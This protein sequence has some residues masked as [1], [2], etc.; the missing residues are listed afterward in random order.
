MSTLFVLPLVISLLLPGCNSSTTLPRGGAACKTD[1]HC[2]LAGVCTAGRC[3]CDP[4]WTD[5]NC[6]ALDLLPLATN[7]LAS[8]G[9]YG[10]HPN[11]SSWG[12]LAVPIKN[13]SSPTGT[14]YHLFVAEMA[15]GCGLAHWG[16]NSRVAHAVA[17]TPQGPFRRAGTAVG[18]FS[19]NPHIVHN[20][21]GL[22][23]ERFVLFHIN[24]GSRILIPDCASKTPNATRPD[25]NTAGA[26]NIRTAPTP[27]GPWRG[28]LSGACNNPA[29][30]RHQNGTWFQLCRDGGGGEQYN[31]TLVRS[32]N[33]F[34]G[35]WAPVAHVGGPVWPSDSPGR[36]N[37][38]DVSEAYRSFSNHPP[39]T[40]PFLWRTNAHQTSLTAVINSL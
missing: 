1:E 3:V 13:A 15:N 9:A 6:S 21:S 2:Q 16:S 8:G 25:G 29:P 26:G 12:G 30:Y 18:V 22:D 14:F 11:V 33:G 24:H 4:G 5:A 40:P 10:Y 27:H 38:E 28:G 17:E 34:K 32:A 19:H 7:D 23:D 35:P 37:C 20:P 31:A 39:P 36:R